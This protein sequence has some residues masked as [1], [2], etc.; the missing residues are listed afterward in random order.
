MD[1]LTPGTTVTELK[2][3][4]IKTVDGLGAI[5]VIKLATGGRYLRQVFAQAD[6]A[7]YSF[8]TAWALGPVFD[9]ITGVKAGSLLKVFYHAPFRNDSTSWGGAY[10]ELQ[11]SVNGG[12]WKSLGSSGYDGGVMK[13]AA[14]AIGAYNNS[15]LVDPGQTADFSIQFRLYCK[16]FDGTAQLNANHDINNISGTATLEVGAQGTQHYAHIIV[17]ELATLKGAL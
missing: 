15:I 12:A 2:T 6:S 4:A 16:S 9:V 10:T 13:N 1:K 3:N 17:E 8:S 7:A 5:D 14:A 11:F